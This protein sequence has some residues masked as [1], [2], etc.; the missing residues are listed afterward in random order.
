[1]GDLHDHHIEHFAKGGGH[2][3]DNLLTLC[4]SHHRDLHDGKLTLEF[5]NGEARFAR[6]RVEA[7]AY[8][9][10]SI[11]PQA[12]AA[13]VGMGFK[14]NEATSFVE[15]AIAPGGKNLTLKELLR[16]ALQRVPSPS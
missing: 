16:E 8:D 4:W 2:G 15:A 6:A 14:R 3:R 10:P 11:V 9:N 13:L 5:E 1:M 12:I 7:P